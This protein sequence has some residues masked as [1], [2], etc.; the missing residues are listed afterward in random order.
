MFAF[1]RFVARAFMRSSETTLPNNA[2]TPS[3]LA[4]ISEADQ[5]AQRV[6][7]ICPLL[8]G[9]ADEVIE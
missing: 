3:S 9:P 6:K 7:H 2:G 8:V 4:A 1:V 5:V